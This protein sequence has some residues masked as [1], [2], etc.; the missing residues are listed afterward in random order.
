MMHKTRNDL[1]EGVRAKVVDL[2]QSR[3]ADVLDPQLQLKQAYWI[4]RGPAFIALHELF[5][6]VAGEVRDHADEIAERIQQLGGRAQGTARCVAAH[7]SLAEHPLHVS[8]GAAHVAAASVVIAACGK[9]VRRAIDRADE[10]GDKDMA[11]LFTG[12]SR[13]L[14]KNLW[15][16]EAHQG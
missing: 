15:F 10:L 1:P 5:D 3:L 13:T 9:L 14:D 8:D 6:D 4:V 7:S 16:V 2:P 12:V 11:D